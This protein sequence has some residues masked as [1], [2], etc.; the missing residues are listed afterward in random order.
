VPAR[1]HRNL[2]AWDHAMK[3]IKHLEL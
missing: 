1:A 2:E 3:T